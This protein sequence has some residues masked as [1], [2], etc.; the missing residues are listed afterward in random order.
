MS[1]KKQQSHSAH[2]LS[3]SLLLLFLLAGI[4][5]SVGVSLALGSSSL[6]MRESLH[7]LAERV[8]LANQL[9]AP[10][11]LPDKYRVIVFD[12][13]LPRIILATIAGA[14]LAVVGSVFQALFRNPLA[15]PHILGISSGAAFGATL[16]LVLGLEGSGWLGLG[17]MGSLAFITALLTVWIVYLAAGRSGHDQAISGM[18]LVG[19]ALGTLF[20]SVISL[21]MLFDHEQIS[22][23]YMW[24]LGSFHGS[25]WSQ[26]SFLTLIAIPGLGYLLTQGRSLNLL[27]SG[28]EEALSMGLEVGKKRK[29][30]ILVASLLVAG[31]VSVSGIIGF[32]GLVIPQYWRIMGQHN[33]RRQ[34]PLC[35]F[36]GALF[37]LW[38]DTAAR[39]L[40][41]PIEIPVGII[42]SLFGV[43]YFIYMVVNRRKRGLL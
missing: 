20:S 42:T 31:V 36:T 15:D 39:T 28:E 26:V 14:I 8:P 23:V 3:W 11:S 32:V 34:L 19:V 21:M 40:L 35:L 13:R 30:L 4:I 18:L 5:L 17:G 43:P 27:L 1:S 10:S 2:S 6:S 41:A 37:M 16:A 7:L 12:L 22:R 25:T 9:V 29:S 24:T 38:C 33:L